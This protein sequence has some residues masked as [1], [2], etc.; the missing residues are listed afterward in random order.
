MKL[1]SSWVRELLGRTISDEEMERTVEKAGLEIEQVIY[2]KELDK[3]IVVGLV[4]K[5]VQHPGADRLKLVS[6]TIGDG[7]LNIVC[8][9][10]NVREGLKVAVAHI[11]TVLPSGDRIEKA[12]LR[13]EVSEG[14]LCSEREL[15]LGSEHDGI[16][17]L[18]D[19][20]E[21]GSALCD[22]YPAETIIDLKTPA[23]R[24]DVLS[25]VGLAREVGAMTGSKLKRQVDPASASGEGPEVVEGSAAARFMLAR[26]GVESGAVSP[27]MAARLKAAGMRSV[28]PVVDVTNYVMLEQGQPMHAYDAAK[29]RLPVE[30]R[31]ARMD[32]R[33]VTLDGVERKLTPED[34]VVA[35]QTGPIGLA[36]V[37]GGAA[38]EVGPETKEILLEA[39]VF[40]SAVVRKMAKRHGIRTEASARFERGLPVQLPAVAM[41]RA[42]E[43]LAMTA[44]GRLVGLTDQQNAKPMRVSIEL[45]ME[46][47]VR[48]VG[49]GMSRK[50]AVEALSRLGF[51]VTGDEVTI[52]VPEVPWWRPD[53]RLAEDLIEEVVRV[54]GYD[55]VP[56]T[57]PAWRPR[58]V[59]FDRQRAK[60]RMVRDLLYGAGLFEVMTYSF[61]AAEQLEELGLVLKDHLKVKNPLSAEQAYLRSSLLP[62]HVAVL[63]RNRLYAKV[64]GF[65]ELSGV[66]VR[67]EAGEQ[68]NE[69]LR[70]GV[71]MRRPERAY[72]AVKGVLDAVGRELNVELVV[73]PAD[74]AEYAP[75]R[76]GVVKLEGMAV[77]RIG[78][79]RPE[80]LDR[81]K[82]AGEAAYVEVDMQTLLDRSGTRRFGGVERFPSIKRD[83]T[84]VVPV[85]V[86]WQMVVDVLAP[87]TAG[88]VGDYYGDDLPEGHKGLTLRLE[89]THPER[90]PTEVEASELEARVFGL[91]ERRLGAKR[92]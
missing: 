50:Q 43:L 73:E 15:G 12:K 75:G 60:R 33:L 55:K 38:T 84:V 16:L 1:L 32:E 37:M 25:M 81:L 23:N 18:D 51:E 77:G 49:F 7:D 19:G 76:G 67:R 66:F 41:G 87:Q 83:L 10:P 88:F 45:A 53:V 74:L 5:V 42:L 68:P 39:A 26:V 65:Y 92:R 48:L 17:E 21:V 89:V 70:L 27:V 86:S 3:K 58:V 30:V 28:S 63:A 69:P 59:A 22:L 14:M 11:G 56:A 44:G 24:F 4:N 90:T 52:V 82:V 35:D 6:V 78:Q 2:S 46:R 13:G 34:L 71:M 54:V 57:I 31:M 47:L 29:V 20:V 64:L 79:L 80:L 62:S 9:A 40:E 72:G 8:G 91:L 61:V 36:G 85:S